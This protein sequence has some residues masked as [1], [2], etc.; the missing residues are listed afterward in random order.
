VYQ[1]GVLP[2]LQIELDTSLQTGTSSFQTATQPPSFSSPLT[3]MTSFFV[4][5]LS[6]ASAVHMVLQTD[7]PS[8]RAYR[9]SSSWPIDETGTGVLRGSAERGELGRAREE[10]GI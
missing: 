3:R 2:L 7:T 8:A 1:P 4:P 10:E 5:C 9:L 6:T